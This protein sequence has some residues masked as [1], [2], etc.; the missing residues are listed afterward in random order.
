MVDA[1]IPGDG[2]VMNISANG[3]P[4]PAMRVNRL[5]SAVM[6]EAS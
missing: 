4:S 1:M 5:I 3:R 6:A 2:A